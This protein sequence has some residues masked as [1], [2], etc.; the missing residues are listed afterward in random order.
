MFF[1][2]T[3][4]CILLLLVSAFAA[5]PQFVFAEPVS[6]R[7]TLQVSSLTGSAENN[8]G[9]LRLVLTNNSPQQFRGICTISLGSD[10]DQREIGQV[11]LM[12]DGDSA[13]RT[14]SHA[15]AQRLAGRCSVRQIRLAPGRQPDQMSDNEIH[16]ILGQ[17]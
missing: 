1:V 6:P 5:E 10:G 4:T 13:G 12:L 3:P 15:A 11:T 16:E 17:T 14:A 7:A 2:L 9:R 8:D